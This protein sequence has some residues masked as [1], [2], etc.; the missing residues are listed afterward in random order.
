MASPISADVGDV[1]AGGVLERIHS[2]SGKKEANLNSSPL[3]LNSPDYP[4]IQFA[5][6]EDIPTP[7]PYANSGRP[8]PLA[9]DSVS[10]VDAASD[11]V[12]P[13]RPPKPERLS[14]PTNAIESNN[15]KQEVSNEDDG[16]VFVA[17]A[18]STTLPRPRPQP[19]LPPAKP[20]MSSSGQ[21]APCNPIESTDF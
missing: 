10:S 13:E 16:S 15:N 4:G 5:D 18:A 7:P 17:G 12:K 20:R 8:V 19:P 6:S 21:G 9:R 1:R 3:T 2:F 11:S 14:Q